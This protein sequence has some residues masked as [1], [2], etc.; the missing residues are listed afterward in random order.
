MT[1]GGGRVTE[2]T[3]RPLLN[4]FYPQLGGIIQPLAGEYGGRRELLEQ[5]AFTSGYGVE[6][7]LLI[8][9]LE[10][11]GLEALAQ[12]DLIERIHH[13]QSLENLSK[14]AFAVSQT[15]FRRL[16]QNELGDVQQSMR[17]LY[18][19]PDELSLLNEDLVEADRPPMRSIPEYRDRY[20]VPERPLTGIKPGNLL[21]GTLKDPEE[22]FMVPGTMT[23]KS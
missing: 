22:V 9:S 3:A 6:T 1:P 10:K 14:M 13:N 17:R 7:S 2:L 11:V 16:A 12:V 15:I 19:Q 21:K 4:M 20:L 8:D 23:S 5:L 18:Q